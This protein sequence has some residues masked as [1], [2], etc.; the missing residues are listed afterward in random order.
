MATDWL[1][2]MQTGVERWLDT[3]REWWSAVSGGVQGPVGTAAGDLADLQR[4]TVEAWRESAA[5]VIDAQ[6]ELMLGALRDRPRADAEALLR[7][8]TDAQ[9]EM[10][11]GWL[12]ILQ[13][14]APS[15]RAGGADIAAAGTQVVD[16][17]REAA[18]HLVKSQADWAKAWTAQ[19]QEAS[20]KRTQERGGP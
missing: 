8:W 14:Q 12:G 10:W 3:Q 19:Q 5:K 15:P 7:R 16:A 18:E 11:Q 20:K 4:R 1:R 13:Q 6:A 17:L 9:R 2:Q